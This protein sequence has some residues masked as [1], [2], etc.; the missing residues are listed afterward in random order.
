MCVFLC[1]LLFAV[2]VAG[3]IAVSQI[4]ERFCVRGTVKPDEIL[5]NTYLNGM[6]LSLCLSL[7]LSLSVSLTNM[8]SALCAMGRL[9]EA[10]A[11]LRTVEALGATSAPVAYAI[12]ITALSGRG[13]LLRAQALF[14]ELR[15]RRGERMQYVLDPVPYIA[16]AQGFVSQGRPMDAEGV[17]KVR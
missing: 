14:E 13:M 5:L 2:L 6:S 12:L 7:S 3:L 16:L 4:F 1:S 10:E 9:D 17:L 11:Q 15:S 8:P